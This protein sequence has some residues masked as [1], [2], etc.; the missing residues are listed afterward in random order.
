MITARFALKVTL[1]TLTIPVSLVHVQR[2]TK[3]LLAVVT[4]QNP[5]WLATVV[6]DTQERCVIDAQKDSLALLKA[7]MDHA[8]AATATLKE[9]S[10]TSAMSSLDNA[11]ASKV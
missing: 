6:K 11:T 9:S 10:L 1:V 8:R 4:F 7:A 3:T 2:P 5:A